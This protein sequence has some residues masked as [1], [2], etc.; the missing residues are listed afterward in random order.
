[1]RIKEKIEEI[2]QFALNLT[3]K[4]ASI[5]VY[6]AGVSLSFFLWKLSTVFKKE[7]KESYWL[8]PEEKED[9]YKSQ[10]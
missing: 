10:Y 7:N 8:E 4:I 9:D 5:F 3:T 1:M 6:W 2:K